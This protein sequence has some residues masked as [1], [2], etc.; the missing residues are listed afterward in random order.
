MKPLNDERD[1]FVKKKERIK[2]HLLR[3]KMALCRFAEQL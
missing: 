3:K 1:Q 2:D